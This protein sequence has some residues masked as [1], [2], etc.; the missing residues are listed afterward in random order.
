MALV[1][2]NSLSGKKEPFKPIDPP[3]VRMYV[4][5]P[6]VYDEPHIGHIRGAFIFDVIRNYLT[7]RGYRVTFVRNVTDIDDKIVARAK[8]EEGDLKA[9]A[10]KVAQKYTETYHSAL[11]ELG[12]GGPDEEPKATEQIPKMVAMIQQLIAQGSA[13]VSEGNVYFSVHSFSDY[14]KLSHQSPDRLLKAHRMEEGPGKQ[15]PLDFALWKRAKPGEPSWESPWGGGR[16]GW[17]MECSVMSQARFGETLDIHG[18]GVDLVF[19]HHENEIAQ[20]ESAWQKPFAKYWMHNGLL[21]VEGQKMAKSVGNVIGIKEILEKGYHPD[22]LKFFFLQSHYRSPVDFSWSRMKEVRNNRISFEIFFIRC[23]EIK[24][25]KGAGK[26]AKREINEIIKPLRSEFEKAM[27]DDFNTPEALSSLFKLLGKGHICLAERRDPTIY[28]AI[29]QEIKELGHILGL[30]SK[31]PLPDLRLVIG[32]IS[33]RGARKIQ[34]AEKEVNCLLSFYNITNQYVSFPQCLVEFLLPR[35]L[36]FREEKKFEIADEI[37]KKLQEFGIIV[38][39]I[40][41]A[42]FTW[43]WQE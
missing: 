33:E 4:C 19:P 28:L 15:N 8:L 9:A 1:I 27:D 43:R 37:R 36:E 40:G 25:N 13:Y 29:R 7:Y 24:N 26:E 41:D 11:E 16:P 21:T 38:E 3:Q 39:D 10:K 18:G 12:I 17:H 31:E 23:S 20:S 22:D 35:R 42:G 2:T 5:G 14:G 30:F 32:E 34:M 6:T